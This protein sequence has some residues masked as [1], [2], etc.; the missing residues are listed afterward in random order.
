[1]RKV[2][3]FLS[4]VLVS[5]AMQ[6]TVVTK[7]ITLSD[8]SGN[9]TFDGSTITASDN[10]WQG[11]YKND[12]YSAFALAES[13]Y[14]E[15]IVELSAE[16]DV[17]VFVQVSYSDALSNDFTITTAQTSGRLT[18]ASANVTSVAIK[19]VD[20]GSATLSKVYFYEVIGKADEDE[21]FTGP[22]DL[23]D[24]WQWDNRVEVSG[25]AFTA[26]HEGDVI[27]YTYTSLTDAQCAVRTQD[28][29]YNLIQLAN[30]GEYGAISPEM[31]EPA[32]CSFMLTATDVANLQSKGLFIT[33]KNM[34]I[35][36]VTL[37]TYSQQIM[38]ETELNS[39]EEVIDWNA[40]WEHTEGL[41]TLA[42]GDELRVVLS[43]LDESNNYQIYFKYDWE[44]EHA[45]AVT[46]IDAITPKVYSVTLTAEQAAA[47][48]AAGK[49]FVNGTGVT[50]SRFAIAQPM[51]IYDERII[52]SGNHAVGSWNALNISASEIS[53][54]KAGNIICI[55]I[56][57]LSRESE[58]D[59][60]LLQHSYTNFDPNVQYRFAANNAVAPMTL[61]IPVTAKMRD[62]LRNQNLT[63]NG[64]NFTI[65]HVIIKEGAPVTTN[66]K[67]LSVTSAGMATF[68]VPFNVQDLP[69]G[70]EAYELTNS[71]D[72]VIWANPVSAL[73]ADKPVL[74]VAAEGEYEFVSEPDASDDISGKTGTYTNGAL[75]GT[76]VGI[77]SI[78]ASDGTV[79]NY[80]LQNG[81]SGVGFYQVK[82]TTCSIAPYRAYLSCGYDAS[83][84]SSSAP[85]MRIVFHKD[86]PTGVES[87]QPS[88]IS[89]Q[90]I[91]RNGQILII[92]DGR[93]YNVLGQMAQ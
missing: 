30:A 53:G 16:P 51:S 29:D 39:G 93:T 45:L 28:A 69:D 19:L 81:A 90:K 15:L 21:I 80:V 22:Q 12:G 46:G 33:G 27:R 24:N 50:L 32:S 37:V 14:T 42:A 7:D 18:L 57:E 66:S 89:S 84:V 35:Q 85:K 72:E 60:V 47:I 62:E 58:D 74:I 65:S 36:N 10:S 70:V 63:I 77:A 38:V 26:A 61:E 48:N 6:A 56:A 73:E 4:A 82:A 13:H 87:I 34:T 43:A 52:W 1:M 9:A 67:F 3:L 8:F 11:I 68:I 25:S 17:N 86:A 91:L 40:H 78:P 5:L 88:V 2:F 55:Q 41:P 54:L 75:V 44:N 83:S 76:Y 79:N 23:G 20:A 49:L 64:L 92:R 71:G 31:S 59:Q